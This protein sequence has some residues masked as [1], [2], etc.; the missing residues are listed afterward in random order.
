MNGNRIHHILTL[1][2][3]TSSMFAGFGSPDHLSM[4]RK[5]KRPAIVILNT[6]P[7][8]SPGEHWCVA[9]FENVNVCFFF[10]SYGCSPAIYNLLPVLRSVHGG[11]IIYNKW[12]IQGDLAKTCGHHC[13]FFALNYAR[14][15]KPNDI[16]RKYKRRNKRYND[17]MVY[18][19][20]KRE[21]GNIIGSI[22]D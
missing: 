21:Y 10:D 3:Y 12:E 6:A 14:G 7:S 4:S 16:M 20:L 1:D 18:G 11:R 9:V 2:P 5:K 19:F 22:E 15:M 13:L 8:T 17:S